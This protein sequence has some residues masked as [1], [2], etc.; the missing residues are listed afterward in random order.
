[1]RV[2]VGRVSEIT[3][4]KG[5]V[6]RLES[7]RVAL[8][9]VGG[10]I[11]CIEDVCTHDDGPLAEGDLEGDVIQCPRH[12]ARFNVTTGAVLSMPAPTPVRT[13]AVEVREGDVYVHLEE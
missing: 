11:H 10:R 8:F 1:M 13:F 5:H 6:R 3:P 12:G 9:N 4:G 7:V 2:K